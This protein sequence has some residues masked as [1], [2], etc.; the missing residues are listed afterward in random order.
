MTRSATPSR[1]RYTSTINSSPIVPN[2]MPTELTL[3]PK[4][5][6]VSDVRSANNRNAGNLSCVHDLSSLVKRCVME[7]NTSASAASCGALS[8]ELTHRN[9]SSLRTVTDSR[10]W[11]VR[12]CRMSCRAT[13]THLLSQKVT[14]TSSSDRSGEAKAVLACKSTPTSFPTGVAPHVPTTSLGSAADIPTDW[15]SR[16]SRETFNASRFVFRQRVIVR[17]FM[18]AGGCWRK[19]QQHVVYPAFDR[20]I[21]SVTCPMPKHFGQPSP[22][23]CGQSSVSF[24]FFTV[25]MYAFLFAAITPANASLIHSPFG[26]SL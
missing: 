2:T 23:H 4:S 22:S 15:R 21:P 17:R 24:C 16:T 11:H 3:N 14:S 6:I 25:W 19:H 13:F 9:R 1:R 8:S 18:P 20:A 7:S 12:F 5:L 26:I 10:I